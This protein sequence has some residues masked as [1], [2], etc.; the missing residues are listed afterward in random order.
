MPGP[1]RNFEKTQY[2]LDFY[3]FEKPKHMSTLSLLIIQQNMNKTRTFCVFLFNL[4]VNK[5]VF[6]IV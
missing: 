2:K 4:F 1:K 5:F 3:Q 6:E